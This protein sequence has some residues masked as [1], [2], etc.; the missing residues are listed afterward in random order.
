MGPALAGDAL[1][2]YTVYKEAISNL[3][4]ELSTVFTGRGGVLGGLGESF[5]SSSSSLFSRQSTVFNPISLSTKSVLTYY[6]SLVKL[7][8]SCAPHVTTDHAPS[9]GGHAH[10][11]RKEG[12][13]LRTQNILRNLA[14]IDDIVDILSLPYVS[15][16]EPGL[17]PT[18]KMEVVGFLERVYGVNDRIVL[19]SLLERAFLPD[20]KLALRVVATVSILLPR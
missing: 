11:K 18:H 14:K 20:I 2:L 7:L 13:D 6:T 3:E 10:N 4:P 1:G 5:S 12:S 9:M 8:A 15:E 16:A 19:L 17:C